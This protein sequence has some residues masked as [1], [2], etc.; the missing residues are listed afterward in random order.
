MAP[1]A[2]APG[3]DGKYRCCGDIFPR[4][5]T[6]V[7]HVRNSHPE[8]LHW[9]K[10]C[11]RACWTEEEL[12]RH[13]DSPLH[14]S[15]NKSTSTK[16]K[17]TCAFR[18]RLFSSPVAMISHLESGTCRSRINR[19]AVDAYVAEKDVRHIIINP[20]LFCGSGTGRKR[21][22][23]LSAPRPIVTYIVPDTAFDPTT[24][25]WLCV[26]CEATFIARQ[27]LSQHVNSPK[28][29]KRD[30]KLYRCPTN[31][32]KSEF[33]LF[34]GVMAHVWDSCGGPAK[35]AIGVLANGLCKAKLVL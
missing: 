27:E 15:A 25:K 30:G 4:R 1:I 17:T 26:L 18:P 3:P 12:Q 34:S 28:H 21:P 6:W 10:L 24:S 33:D 9:C 22:S 20:S 19:A 8:L 29:N 35:K 5:S 14:R 7:E 11:G 31:G 13:S 23:A 2:L 16:L 32:C